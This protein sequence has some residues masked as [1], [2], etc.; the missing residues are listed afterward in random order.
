MKADSKG[1]VEVWGRIHQLDGL[2]PTSITSGGDQLLSSPVKLNL[3]TNGEMSEFKVKSLKLEIATKGRASYLP[4][5]IGSGVQ[6]EME[7][8]GSSSLGSP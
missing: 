3:I 2:L 4:A 8:Q 6:F 5:L 1:R 7:D